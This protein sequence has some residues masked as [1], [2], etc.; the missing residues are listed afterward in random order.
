[1]PPQTALTSQDKDAGNAQ[2]VCL[3]PGTGTVAADPLSRARCLDAWASDPSTNARMRGYM[4]T[5]RGSLICSD[6]NTE[7]WS[8]CDRTNRQPLREESDGYTHS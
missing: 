3:V 1:M 5:L 8:E 7:S 4:I 6:F 2:S